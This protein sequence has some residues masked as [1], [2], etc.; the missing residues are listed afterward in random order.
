M[1]EE[2]KDSQSDLS[3]NSTNQGE[4]RLQATWHC[5][6]FYLRVG[7]VEVTGVF[8]I[9]P[10]LMSLLSPNSCSAAYTPLMPF[11]LDLLLSILSLSDFF[12]LDFQSS[13]FFILIFLCGFSYHHELAP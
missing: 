3:N 4:V 9:S 11:S 2:L 10:L 12:F 13:A 7:E 5:D 1:L 8:S 6:R